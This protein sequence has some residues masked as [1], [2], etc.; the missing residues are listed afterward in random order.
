M[1]AKG[2][3]SLAYFPAKFQKSMWIKHG[4]FRVL[5][6]NLFFQSL[7]YF[8]GT[9]FFSF[10]WWVHRVSGSF[11]VVDESGKEKA[12]GSGSKV[13]S[14]VLQVLFYEQVRT[15]QRSPDW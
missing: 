14:K 15:L 11:V 8:V 9:F 5:D 13:G 3:A 12:L 2:D 10:S 4:G 6:F 1:D 7:F